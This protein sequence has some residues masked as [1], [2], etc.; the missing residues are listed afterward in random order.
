[1]RAM[2]LPRYVPGQVLSITAIDPVRA[3]CELIE[4]GITTGEAINPLRVDMLLELLEDLPIY[5]LRHGGNME[6]VER[7]LKGLLPCN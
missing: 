6:E 5:L 7:A 2:V 4:T 1:M 3:L